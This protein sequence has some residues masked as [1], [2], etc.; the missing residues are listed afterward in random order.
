M[1]GLSVG[2]SGA[3][4]PT[5]T[6]IS[7]LITVSHTNGAQSL[8]HN[9]GQG[10]SNFSLSG[11]GASG[12]NA[13]LTGTWMT[14]PMA[15][16]IVSLNIKSNIVADDIPAGTTKHAVVMLNQGYVISSGNS[17]SGPRITRNVN[18]GT[19]LSAGP[20]YSAPGNVGDIGTFEMLGQMP[21]FTA[22]HRGLII[23]TNYLGTSGIVSPGYFNYTF[24]IHAD[25]ATKDYKFILELEVSMD[26]TGLN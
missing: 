21:V 6:I 19:A 2:A 15:A 12:I 14:L 11:F 17:T 1:F 20:S 22:G 16:S 24:Q 10:E 7:E 8:T 9:S 18:Q 3:I 25:Y 23:G 13:A 5:S 4:Q 26:S